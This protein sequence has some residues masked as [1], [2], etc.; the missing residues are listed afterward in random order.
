MAKE[1]EHPITPA[2]FSVDITYAGEM[3]VIW[4]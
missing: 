2:M 3:P 4:L 1:N